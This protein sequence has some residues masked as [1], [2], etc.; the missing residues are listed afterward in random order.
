MSPVTEL[1]VFYA[2]MFGLIIGSFA[3]VVIY[4]VPSGQSVVSPRSSCPQ[5]DV[6]IG[7]R[8]NIPVLSWL[9]LKA[10]CRHCSQPIPWIYPAVELGCGALFMIVAVISPRLGL[11]PG[12]C[13]L[14][15]ACLMLALIDI[16][17]Y[18][19]PDKIVAAAAVIA[20]G[21]VSVDA[22]IY[23]IDDGQLVRTVL[24]TLS[25]LLVFAI[26][27]LVTGG[28]GM[29][30]GDVKLAPILGFTLGWIG[31]GTSLVGLFAG[32]ALGTLI[33]L[34]VLLKTGGVRRGKTIPYGPFMVT[35]AFV[36]I[37]A[38]ASLWNVYLDVF[39][40]TV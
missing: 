2:G 12:L 18:T 17:T 4:R 9:L 29:G 6:P 32:F 40:P 34:V 22:A 10:R 24:S 38:G 8:D 26:P 37:A 7:W 20:V 39:F 30:F 35:G 13:L 31:W 16:A 15:A 11:I 21:T 33:G 14:A 36:G 3:N 25:W 23:G 19:L 27:W 1:A 28:K 5:C